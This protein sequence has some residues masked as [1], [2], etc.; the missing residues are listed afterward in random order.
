MKINYGKIILGAVFYAV[1]AQIVHT[2][3][4]FLTM[5]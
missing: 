1:I 2:L 5:G 3:G 4:A